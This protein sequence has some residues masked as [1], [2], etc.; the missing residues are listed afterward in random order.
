MTTVRCGPRAASPCGPTASID[1]ENTLSI[2]WFFTKLPA[3]SQQNNL[4]E[5]HS[6]HAPIKQADGRWI[7]SHIINQDIV[8]WVGQGPVSDRTKENLGASDRGIAMIRNRFFEEMDATAAGKDAKGTIR[9]PEMAK[10]VPL[11]IAEPKLYKDIVPREEWVSNGY[12]KRR[13]KE[14]PWH[15]GQPP[16]ILNAFQ[17]A[18]GLDATGQPFKG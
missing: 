5:I 1:D 12:F 3:E 8:A 18:V 15:Y 13:L 17:K 14:F 7:T 10:C 11:P 6:W 16:E 9:D 2:T 4:P